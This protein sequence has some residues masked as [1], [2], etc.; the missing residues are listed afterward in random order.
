MKQILFISICMALV[1]CGS[2]PS[3]QERKKPQG[4]TDTF[5]LTSQ[6]LKASL[7]LRDVKTAPE[8][9]AALRETSIFS[10]DQPGTAAA[11]NDP[12]SKCHDNLLKAWP[13]KASGDTIE[14]YSKVDYASC[15]K[16]EA[17]QGKSG[18]ETA[19]NYMYFQCAGADF[20]SLNGKNPTDIDL[21]KEFNAQ[22]GTSDIYHQSFFEYAYD[23]VLHDDIGNGK[24]SKTESAGKILLATFSGDMKPCVKSRKGDVEIQTGCT[25]IQ[26]NVNSKVLSD[27]KPVEQLHDTELLITARSKDLKSSLSNP[28]PWFER[29]TFSVKLNSWSGTLEYSSKHQ[30]PTFLFKNGNEQLSGVLNN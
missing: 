9:L 18:S 2:E 14:W 16:H 11:S 23:L 6:D 10:P 3:K 7:P 20:S 29:G 24:K 22:C 12:Y 30:G 8:L 26:R 27:G 28:G 21:E 19:R 5:R 4:S 25:H 1:A 15:W 13:L 17:D